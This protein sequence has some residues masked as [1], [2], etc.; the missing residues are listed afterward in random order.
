MKNTSNEEEENQTPVSLD[1]IT[2]ADEI[3]LSQ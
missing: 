3:N 1:D 2:E